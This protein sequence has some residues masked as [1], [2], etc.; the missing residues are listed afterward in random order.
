[1]KTLTKKWQILIYGCAGM[2]VNMLNLIIGSYLCSALLTGGFYK[3]VEYW[4]FA[5]KDLVIA[6]VWSVIVLVAKIIDGVIDIPMASFTDNLRTRFGKRRPAILGG[7][8][9]MIA[10]YLMFLIPMPAEATIGNTVFF[11]AALC[12]FYTFYTLTMVTYYA[13]FS[14]IVDNESDRM[15]LSN[16]KS[17]CDIVYF[18]LGYALLPILVNN[19]IN[20]ST[21]ALIFLPLVLTM[22][23][24]LVMI[25]GDDNRNSTEA[26]EKSI[27]LVKS[28]A[29]TFKDKSFILWMIVYFFMTMG[30]QLFLGGINEFFST[31]DL[32]MTLVMMGAFAPV[33]FTLILF[34]H[35]TKKKGFGFSF[36]YTLII[37]AIGMIAMFFGQAAKDHTVK[38]IVAIASAVVGSFGIGSLF[39]VAYS[40]PSQLAAEEERRSGVSHSAMYFAVQG[41]F[42]GVA[43]GIATGLI[44]VALKDNVM[45]LFG[46]K[47][48]EVVDGVQTGAMVD[49][50]AVV[51]MTLLAGVFCLIAFAF[52]FLLPKS[53][54][55]FGKKNKEEVVEK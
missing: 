35:L 16:V 24:P 6:G 41:L 12:L 4:T 25:K 17:V 44:L 39:S 54:K 8:V 2:G 11:G 37:Y 45:P 43:S 31:N 20:I 10:A 28:V 51:L 47:I 52:M 18:I 38:V 3:N 19:H 23:I 1:M 42:S 40:I 55:D 48:P 36:G 34:N 50:S 33:P 27:S 22:L 29:F 21:V 15:F 32:P 5:N 26:K 49:P 46:I 9:L 7:M 13:T 53:I 14:E 30:V